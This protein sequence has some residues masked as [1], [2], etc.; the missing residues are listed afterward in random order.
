M[1]VVVVV[2]N[3]IVVVLWLIAYFQN[4][5]QMEK[6]CVVFME[7]SQEYENV[8]LI[9]PLRFKKGFF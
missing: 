5:S 1:M 9:P 8:I 4:I 6:N 2:T 7:R 3:C